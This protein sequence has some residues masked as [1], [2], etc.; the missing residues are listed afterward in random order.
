MVKAA[1]INWKARKSVALVKWKFCHTLCYKSWFGFLVV[2]QNHGF[3]C[4]QMLVIKPF[5]RVVF[6]KWGVVRSGE[7]QDPCILNSVMSH[8]ALQHEY[9]NSDIGHKY[10]VENMHWLFLCMHIDYPA[11]YSQRAG[12]AYSWIRVW[13][14]EP[15]LYRQARF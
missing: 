2:A 5:I 12:T 11:Y 4:T 6:Y 7:R 3:N 14:T 1:A 15:I 9:I 8:G 10:P 13:H